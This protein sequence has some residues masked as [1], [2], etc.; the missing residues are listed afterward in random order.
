MTTH[1]FRMIN[2]KVF[3]VAFILLALSL[4]VWPLLVS[5]LVVLI[6]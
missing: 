2:Q 3:L 1:D 5:L 4:M 6:L